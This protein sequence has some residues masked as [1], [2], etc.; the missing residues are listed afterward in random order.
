M[1]AQLVTKSIGLCRSRALRTRAHIY[2]GVSRDAAVKNWCQNFEF[3]V[4][5]FFSGSSTKEVDNLT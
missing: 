4:E 1:Q 3:R 5:C 2:L